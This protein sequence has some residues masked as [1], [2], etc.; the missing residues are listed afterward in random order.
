MIL[1]QILWYIARI[2]I[3]SV[4]VTIHQTIKYKKIKILYLQYFKCSGNKY[5]K[6]S[7]QKYLSH[8]MSK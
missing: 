2:I 6:I 8:L 1:W 3:I 5:K 7:L 4:A